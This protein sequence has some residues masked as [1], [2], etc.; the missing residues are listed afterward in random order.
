MAESYLVLKIFG[1]L[2]TADHK[3]LREGCESRNNH[4]YAV[5]VQDRSILTSQHNQKG[6][7]L[8]HFKTHIRMP[9]KQE[10]T[11]GT[12]QG[13]SY[14]AITLNPESNYTRREKNH[15]LFH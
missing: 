9:V 6:L 2:I 13:T 4:R 8:H 10:I 5:V 1:V 12:C 15:S 14:T 7:H 3:V 11:F